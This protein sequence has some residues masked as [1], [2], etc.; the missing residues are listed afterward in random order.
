MKRKSEEF[1]AQV[2]KAYENGEGSYETLAER[3]GV[4]RQA[5]AQHGKKE[6]W[7]KNATKPKPDMQEVTDKLSA[8]AMR[9]LDRLSESE[10]EPDVKTIRELAALMK[11]LNQLMKNAEESGGEAKLRVQWGEEEPWSE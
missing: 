10:G 9:A 1:W 2:R 4:C 5:V 7:V 8:A 3:F 6:G 11:E